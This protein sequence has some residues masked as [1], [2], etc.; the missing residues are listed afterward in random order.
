MI[1]SE[2]GIIQTKKRGQGR[3]NDKW[4]ESE[5]SRSLSILERVVR[6]GVQ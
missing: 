3:R 2:S 4:I 6:T 5:Q 1:I